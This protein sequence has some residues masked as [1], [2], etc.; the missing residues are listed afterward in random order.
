[1]TEEEEVKRKVEL[2]KTSVNDLAPFR[3]KTEGRKKKTT[4]LSSCQIVDT[5]WE[6]GTKTRQGGKTMA[7]QRLC[8]MGG[9]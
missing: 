6:V 1:M 7:E 8:Q 2:N 5:A 4:Q 3:V 9:I